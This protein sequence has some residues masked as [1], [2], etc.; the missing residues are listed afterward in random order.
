[1][2]IL[3]EGEHRNNDNND[4]PMQKPWIKTAERSRSLPWSAWHP[5][6]TVREERDTLSG[7]PR[8]DQRQDRL[9]PQRGLSRVQGLRRRQGGE[10]K[11]LGGRVFRTVTLFV[12]GFF[13]MLL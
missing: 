11:E 13:P 8:T 2:H 5:G 1:M 7:D 10:I 9:L 6:A 4:V 3:S 12:E